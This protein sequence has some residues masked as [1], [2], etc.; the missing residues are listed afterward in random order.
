[1]IALRE[2]RQQDSQQVLAWRNLPEVMQYMYSDHVITQEEHD[3]WFE[4][5][6]GDPTKRYWIVQ[7]DGQDVGVAN[8][9]D[10]DFRNRS[11]FWA[12]YLASPSVR[13]RGVGSFVEYFV[14]RYV[15]DELELNKL[16]CEVFLFNDSVI[17]MHKKF[18]FRE[19]G[20]F[21]AHIFKSGKFHDVMRLAILSTEWNSIRPE[22]EER[23]RSKGFIG[24]S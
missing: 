2:I 3:A 10:I 18:G 5:M 14:L 9:T 11:C 23:L 16:S 1:M 24:G 19:E 17:D 13:G 22:I 6:L 4:R 8:I 12:F 15:F 20:I 21:R 7:L